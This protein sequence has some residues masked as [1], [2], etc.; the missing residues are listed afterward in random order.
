MRAIS[1]S[2]EDLWEIV[3]IVPKRELRPSRNRWQPLLVLLLST[4]PGCSILFSEGDVPASDA[5]VGLFDAGL[6][7]SDAGCLQEQCTSP[8]RM[9]LHFDS[10]APSMDECG[11]ELTGMLDISAPTAG[12]G[13]SLLLQ[14]EKVATLTTEE[15]SGS[16][17]LDFWIYPTSTNGTLLRVF[18]DD[19]E[20]MPCGLEMTMEDEN[21]VIRWRTSAGN[22]TQHGTPPVPLNEWSH[23]AFSYIHSGAD[24]G[25]QYSING[26]PLSPPFSIN[27]CDKAFTEVS[28]G[29]WDVSNVTSS[30]QGRIDEVRL[31]DV[32]IAI[33]TCP[34]PL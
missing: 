20:N 4:S 18:H 6:L 25:T 1:C 34:L 26:A 3:V 7:Q 23:V 5:T 30:I 27:L 24:R 11:G 10:T 32:V 14:P 16:W 8:T 15:I 28:I 19:V 17:T 31:Q 29:N 2:E 9:L 13:E 12:L 33:D 22:R 21:L